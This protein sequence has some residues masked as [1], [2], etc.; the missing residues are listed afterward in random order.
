M[1]QGYMDTWS[2]FLILYDTGKC[3]QGVFAFVYSTNNEA[4]IG[5]DRLCHKFHDLFYNSWRIGHS[6]KQTL[7]Q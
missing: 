3:Y 4:P 5:W 7:Y 6:G 1:L 2:Q